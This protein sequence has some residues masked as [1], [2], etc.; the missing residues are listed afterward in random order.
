MEQ[1]EEEI[2]KKVQ[3]N[4]ET[5][6]SYGFTKEKNKYIY[7]KKVINSLEAVIEITSTKEVHG[8]IYDCKTNEEYTRFRSEE[9]T[10]FAGKVKEAYQNLLEDICKHCCTQKYFVFEQA[11]RIVELLYHMYESKPAFLWEKYPSYAVFKT[12]ESQ[13]WFAVLLP[14]DKSKISNE[15]GKT[16]ILLVKAEEEQ[17]PNLLKRKGFYKGYHLNKKHWI[18]IVLDDTVEEEEIKKCLQDSYALVSK[19]QEWLIPANP[20]YYDVFSCF[21]EKLVCEWKQTTK[22]Q[23]HD[24]VYIYVANPFCGILYKCEVEEVNIPY[25]YKDKNL[26]INKVMK[27]KLMKRYEEGEIPFTKL[28]EL[29]ITAIRGPR[30]ITK[31]I[32]SKF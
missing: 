1:L 4:M 27:L 2:F 20:K 22:V 9:N 19:K 31:Q 21:K 5:L 3:I 14:I 15:T 10:I 32:S 12:K 6:E 11:N 26:T 7:S 30:K 24:I 17:I 16:E 18:S 25:T 23:V 28:K 29:G 13:K 8:K